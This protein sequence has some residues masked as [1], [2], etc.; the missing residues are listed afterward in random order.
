MKLSNTIK[1]FYDGLSYRGK[2]KIIFNLFFVGIIL[3]IVLMTAVNARILS[4]EIYEKHQ[5]KLTHLT[6]RIEQQFSAIESLT[7]E[8]HQNTVLQHSLE[9]VNDSNSTLPEY[10]NAVREG[11]KELTWLLADKLEVTDVLL[12]DQNQKNLSKSIY[13][14]EE[15]FDGHSLDLIMEKLPINYTGG[16]WFF[17]DDMSRGLFVQNIY[18]TKN[19]RLRRSGVLFVFVNTGFISEIIN[20]GQVFQNEDFFVLESGKERYSTNLQKLAELNPESRELREVEGSGYHFET[21]AN[22]RYFVYNRQLATLTNQFEIY[23]FLINN[24]VLN[25]VF[26][27]LLIFALLLTLFMFTSY[28]LVNRN[29]NKLIDPINQLVAAM[30]RFKGEKDLHD[31][32]LLQE[33]VGQVV[34]NDEIG[35]LYQSF[36]TL[37]TEIQDLVIKDYRSKIL[38]HEME[39]KFLQA[40]LDPHFLFNTLNTINWMAINKGDFEISEMVTALS[41]LFR[42]KIDNDS[43]FEKLSEELELINAYIKIQSVRYKSRL[44]FVKEVDD[45]LLNAEIPQLIIQ[46]LI[47]NS[48]KYGVEKVK[49]PVTVKL[50]V[51]Q[52]DGQLLIQVCDNGPGFSQQTGARKESTGLGIANIRSRLEILYGGQAHFEIASV[53]DERTT[54]TMIMPMNYEEMTYDED[55]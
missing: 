26:M 22:G 37:I 30:K 12:F 7:T 19:M 52:V 15:L 4:Q 51:K 24:Q 28:R 40:Q 46:P 27:N 55:L 16:Q 10:Q 5:E 43:R 25:K 3:F 2:F 33:P 8:I 21:T 45:K 41:V 31:L 53:P 47:E 38:A 1:N 18:P 44:D 11:S 54:I 32:Q 35:E 49:R 36:Q 39:Y 29:L 6:Q 14:A 23:Y 9:V 48:L 42:K 50:L 34:R 20:D 17:T 13:N